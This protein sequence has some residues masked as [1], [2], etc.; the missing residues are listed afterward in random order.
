MPWWQAI[1]KGQWFFPAQNQGGP[2]WIENNAH[3]SSMASA[4][5]YL[6]FQKGIDDGTDYPCKEGWTHLK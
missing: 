6:W 1:K 2:P 4:L 5:A 3:G